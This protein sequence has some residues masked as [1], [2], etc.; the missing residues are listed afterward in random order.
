MLTVIVDGNN[1]LIALGIRRPEQAEQFLQKLE[2]AAVTKDWEA[3][4][5]FDGPERYLPRE[6]GPLIVRYMKGKTADSLIE[7]M[8]CQAA[9]RAQVAVV[10]QDRAE[11]DLVRGFGGQ[12]WSPRRLMEELG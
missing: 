6:S 3:V 1:V 2:M 9:D 4:V 12:V 10:T 5:V 11:G 8:A 7:R